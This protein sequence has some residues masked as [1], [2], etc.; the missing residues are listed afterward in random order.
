MN[1]TYSIEQVA[2]MT[3]LSTRTIRNYI[4]SGQLKGDKS[5]GVWQFT[6]EQF[7]DF[8]EQD[9]VRQSVQAKANG[10]VYDFLLSARRK[11]RAACLILD[12]PVK[13]G[14]E[15][16]ALREQ[17]MESANCRGLAV[18]YRFEA[19]SARG[20]LT[21]APKTLAEAVQEIEEKI[22]QSS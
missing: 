10:I 9:M 1:Q 18:S 19:D 17:L 20:I 11:E 4:A 6:T 12:W 8:L 14:A 3:G 21:G 22:S 13:G 2:S 16:R 15:E 7:S 5:G